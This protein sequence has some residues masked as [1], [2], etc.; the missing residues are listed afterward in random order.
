MTL[1][2]VIGGAGFIGSRVV[3]ELVAQGRKVIVIGRKPIPPRALPPS[4]KYFSGNF[5]DTA[6]LAAALQGV[7]E[8][9]DLAYA[10][11]P[12]TSYDDPVQDILL[13]LPP[14]VNL[15]EVASNLSITKLIV[16]SSGGV[17]YGNATSIPITENHPTNPISPYG[18][19]KL[20]VE[21][22]AL[23]FNRT[24]SLP[25]V[26]VRPANAFGE[27]QMPF[28]GQGFVSTAIGSI[29]TGK[30][31]TI[32]GDSGTVRDYIHVSD[33][34]RGIVA[35]LELG[36]TGTIYNIG[37][38][39][40]RTNQD[41]LNAIYPLAKSA[42]LE[43]KVKILPPRSFDVPANILDST[44]LTTETGW[45]A[46]VSFEAGIERTWAWLAKQSAI[47]NQL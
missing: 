34:A 37:S 11:V 35:V 15:F 28:V 36:K 17:I 31:I 2:C 42:G 4:V 3:E 26:C 32:F 45:S 20:A 10:S 39:V 7:D 29:L 46:K 43:P 16:V 5:G 23:A 12:K 24:K 38:G 18:I 9:I 25:V 8:I 21:K 22:Y 1:C 44:K 14:V 19:T 40:G 47:L 6:F 33:V 13:N 30:E 27:G 41:V